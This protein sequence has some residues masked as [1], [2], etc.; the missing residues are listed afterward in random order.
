MPITVQ[1][2]RRLEIWSDWVAAG[3][4]RTY[5][6]PDATNILA[7]SNITLAE[8][9]TFVIPLKSAT[10][11]LVFKG[12][13]L[14]LDQDDVTFDE[15]KVVNRVD[16]TQA[17]TAQITAGTFANTDL[18]TGAFLSRVDSDGT[19]NYEFES[20]G[21]DPTTQIIQ[22]VIPAT[23]NFVTI[24]T[25]NSTAPMDM[26]YAWDKPLGALQRIAANLGEL[27]V[28][29]VGSVGYAIDIVDQIGHDA[30]TCDVRVDKNIIR[31]SRSISSDGQ[32]TRI[33]PQGQAD[34]DN[35]RATM[36]Q[37]SWLVTNI[38]SVSG[39]TVVTLAD[40]AGNEG[41]I[42]FDG[43]LVGLGNIFIRSRFGTCFGLSQS[44]ATDQTVTIPIDIGSVDISIG[45]FVDFRTDALP[46]GASSDL[47]WLDSPSDVATWG[48]I[49]APLDVGDT[50]GHRNLALNSAL[51]QWSGTLPDN[52][53]KVGT[54]TVTKQTVAPY[55]LSGSNSLKI[56]ATSDGQG[57]ETA[58]VRITPSADNPFESGFGSVWT[59]TDPGTVRVELVFTTPDGEIVQPILPAVASNSESG[60]WEDI[61]IS[62]QDAHSFGA[63]AVRLRVVQ[64]G[65]TPATFYVGRAQLTQS[66]AQLP[67][68]EGSGGTKLWQAANEQLRTN[69]APTVAYEAT[70]ADLARIDPQTWGQDCT[71]TVGGSVLVTDPRFPLQILT[72]IVEVQRNYSV[73]GNTSI[74]IS[75]KP[76]DLSG[77]YARPK[78]KGRISPSFFAT[79]QTPTVSAVQADLN[80]AGNPSVLI[81]A[82]PNA[83]SLK[84]AISTSGVPT[85][86]DVEAS[87]AISGSQAVVLFGAMTVNPGETLYGKVFAYRGDNGAGLRS[88]PMPFSIPFAA[89]RRDAPW[90]DGGYALAASDSAGLVADSGVTDSSGLAS[91]RIVLSLAKASAGAPDDLR[92]VPDGGGYNRTTSS[93]VDSSGRIIQVAPDG[94]IAGINAANLSRA[95]GTGVWTESFEDTSLSAW[96]IY[97][98]PTQ[99]YVTPSPI[100]AYGRYC[101]YCQGQGGFMFNRN[102]PFDPRKLYRVRIA[103]TVGSYGGGSAVPQYAGL[104]A[105]KSD[106]VTYIT[107]AGAD[108]SSPA[109]I[110]NVSNGNVI[111]FTSD[112]WVV[113]TG[114]VKGYG[115]FRGTGSDPTN[116]ERMPSGTVYIRPLATLNYTGTSTSETLID[117]FEIT[118]YDDDGSARTYGGFSGIGSIASGVTQGDAAGGRVILRGQQQGR[119]KN[120]DVITFSPPYQNV[121]VVEITD[122]AYNEP[123]SKWGSTGDGTEAGAVQDLPQYPDYQA[124]GLSGSGFTLRARLRQKAAAVTAEADTF[125]NNPLT[126]IGDVTDPLALSSPPGNGE[127]YTINLECNLTLNH[128]T[129]FSGTE[130]ISLVAAIDVD[131]SGLGA[132]S[133]IAN[134]TFTK[135]GTTGGSQLYEQPVPVAVEGVTSSTLF[136]VRLKDRIDI[137][138]GSTG[139]LAGVNVQYDFVTGGGDQ[140]ASKTPDSNDFVNWTAR[141]ASLT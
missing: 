56:V 107:S 38:A 20:V 21:L 139:V 71:I 102:I 103:L 8:K 112:N 31:L 41:P 30:A 17:G 52:W 138:A 57:I 119:A 3:G 80:T 29:R 78:K 28:R 90:A 101:L 82:T 114:W 7:V 92:S 97:Y 6:I 13:V 113:L 85:D 135:S 128:N 39:S 87:T 64:N 70:I 79:P 132:W 133:E 129:D 121:P 19:R 72:R 35:V 26:A 120:G 65:V 106:G 98:A 58:D 5:V 4:E 2:I 104:G 109:A 131:I 100:P 108:S 42:G 94:V 141:E 89:I 50:P 126:V 54:P 27:N 122:G 60:Q 61:G 44:S 14:R 63:T 69:G 55:V 12:V 75:S 127:I 110:W 10:S 59:V 62:G 96:T 136:R 16:D 49:I 115:T 43:Q 11:P 47:T 116:P 51:R 22:W 111:S 124:L 40:P 137:S 67:F 91:R 48:V 105:I 34:A 32:A 76:D 15:W 23:P 95:Q 24:G 45:D 36:A 93:F 83:G 33:F 84:V 134:Y 77:S 37:A 68:V 123:R 86:A 1:R 73:P 99:Y 118:E 25:I 88:P 130:Y 53:A 18:V 66:P 46:G 81:I 140:F 74:T 117:Y 9:L 125:S